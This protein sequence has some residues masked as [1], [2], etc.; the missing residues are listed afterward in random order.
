MPLA[1]E[2][3]GLASLAGRALIAAATGD[4]W[5]GRDLHDVPPALQGWLDLML[6]ASDLRH[7]HL[8]VQ[9]QGLPA[10]RMGRREPDCRIGIKPI[11]GGGRTPVPQGTRDQTVYCPRL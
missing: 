8:R 4:G 9:A 1:D 3:A 10:V 5:E 2:L 11:R 7:V 6:R